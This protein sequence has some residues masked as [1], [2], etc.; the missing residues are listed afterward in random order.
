MG[1]YFV[2]IVTNPSREVL[3]IG[4]TN[5]LNRRLLEHFENRGNAKT[6]AGRYFCY[7]LVYFERHHSAMAAIEREK[8]IKKWS[9][10]KKDALIKAENPGL[11]FINA[12]VLEY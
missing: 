5:D 10:K 3:Y 8:E 1:N 2:Y 7:K 9:R 6:F 4:M 12:E 11:R